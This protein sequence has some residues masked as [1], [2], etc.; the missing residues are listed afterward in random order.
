MLHMSIHLTNEHNKFNETV[1]IEV[2]PSVQNKSKL[3]NQTTL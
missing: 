3:N 2:K 1:M